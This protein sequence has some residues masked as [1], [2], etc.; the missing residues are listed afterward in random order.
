M[1]DQMSQG[2]IDDLGRQ[3]LLA[4]DSNAFTMGVVISF[5]TCTTFSNDPIGLSYFPLKVKDQ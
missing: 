1:V 5:I 4:C 2:V 3:W